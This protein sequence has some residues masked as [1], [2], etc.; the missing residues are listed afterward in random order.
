MI[1]QTLLSSFVCLPIKQ[2]AC[3][4]LKANAMVNCNV[5]SNCHNTHTRR[6]SLDHSFVEVTQQFSYDIC[7]MSQY[8]QENASDTKKLCLLSLALVSPSGN[9]NIDKRAAT[10]QA[11][12]IHNRRKL[13]QGALAHTHTRTYAWECVQISALSTRFHVTQ[14]S[15]RSLYACV[16]VCAQTDKCNK[17]VCMYVGI[18]LSHQYLSPD[19]LPGHLLCLVRTH[20]HTYLAHITHVL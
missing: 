15:L 17:N 1:H 11:A 16:W 18:S 5:L 20:T 8:W 13:V 12:V 6:E 3:T 9:K 19:L 2:Y 14:T 4:T 10:Q 7:E